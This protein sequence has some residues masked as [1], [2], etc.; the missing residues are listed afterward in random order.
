MED[1]YLLNDFAQ[2]I[3]LG[4]EIR[5]KKFSIFLKKHKSNAF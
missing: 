4:Q 3:I 1:N 5:T 2:K